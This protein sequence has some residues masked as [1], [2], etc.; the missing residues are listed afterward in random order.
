[1]PPKRAAETGR[2]RST[3]T[4]ISHDQEGQKSKYFDGDDS[5]VDM[6]DGPDAVVNGHKAKRAKT[7][8]SSRGRGRRQVDDDSDGD[9][10]KEADEEEDEPEEDGDYDHADE[11]DADDH[12]PVKKSSTPAKAKPSKKATARGKKKKPDSDDDDLEEDE[13]EDEDEDAP[14]KVTFIPNKKLHDLGGV[15]HVDETVHPVTMLFLK[16]L[17]ANNRRNWLKENDGEFR[18]AQ[19]DW[20]SFVDT[21]G[22]RLVTDVDETIPELP[23]KDIVFRI[24]RDIRFSKDPRPYK[25]HFSAA[26][27]RTGKKGPYAHYYIHCEPGSSF[28]GAGMWHPDNEQLR[29]LRTSIDERP[30]RWR[31]VL[32]EDDKVRHT[33]FPASTKKGDEKACI[34]AFAKINAENALKKKPL[35]YAADHRDIELLKLRNFHVHK[36]VP[37]SLFTAEDAQDQIIFF[38]CAPGLALF[39]PNRELEHAAMQ[40]DVVC[41]PV[42]RVRLAV[43]GRVLDILVAVRRVKVDDT[44]HGV[45][46][47]VARP[48]AHLAEERRC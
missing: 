13:D 35:G 23:A 42:A 22:S 41:D 11:E 14:A 47:V 48:D 31:R 39:R 10:Y 44:Q 1:M 19:K 7:M 46:L 15:D 36:R 45:R 28:V 24:Y 30:H 32:V 2:R 43:E 34:K 18:R 17:K 40:E 12:K 20:L 25:P 26:W 21:F 6:S 16:D 3:R 5:D 9:D 38:A 4:S 27:S 29:L 8:V 37:D 33:F